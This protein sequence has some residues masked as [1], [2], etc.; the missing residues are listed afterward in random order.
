VN[1]LIGSYR[2]ERKLLDIPSSEKDVF[3]EQLLFALEGERKYSSA[4]LSDLNSLDSVW[5]LLRNSGIFVRSARAEFEEI[6]S[7][8]VDY[9]V[10]QC[11]PADCTLPLAYL[12]SYD[13]LVLLGHTDVMDRDD[14]L[15]LLLVL[16]K[17]PYL[18]PDRPLLGK[19]LT[20]YLVPYLMELIRDHDEQPYLEY[21]LTLFP[22]GDLVE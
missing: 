11:A 1:G 22:E 16:I 18:C 20:E 3:R 12:L 17:L 4:V 10:G 9:Y 13:R 8:M 7:Q 14:F 2:P 19:R 5:I 21:Y 6:R 15:H